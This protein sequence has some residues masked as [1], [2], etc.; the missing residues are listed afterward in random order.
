M[1]IIRSHTHQNSSIPKGAK[2]VNIP[3]TILIF[4][5]GVQEMEKILHKRKISRSHSCWLP[6]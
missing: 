4:K 5:I 2:L 3:S 6:F 1:D